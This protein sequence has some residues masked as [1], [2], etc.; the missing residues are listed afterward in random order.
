MR[1]H[2]N[3]EFKFREEF[4]PLAPAI[5]DEYGADWFENHHRCR[6]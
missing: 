4:R 2:I 5:L 6:I 1:E 3:S